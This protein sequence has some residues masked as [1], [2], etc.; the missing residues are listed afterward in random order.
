MKFQGFGGGGGGG[1][2]GGGL[3]GGGG[4]GGGWGEAGGGGGGG[5][6]SEEKLFG[7]G[8]GLW[9]NFYSRFLAECTFPVGNFRH[10]ECETMEY[11][12]YTFFRKWKCALGKE[13]KESLRGGP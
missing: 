2:G 13:G 9:S 8:E 10:S 12:K 11:F 5:G 7:G 3:G 6:E 1:N 4:G